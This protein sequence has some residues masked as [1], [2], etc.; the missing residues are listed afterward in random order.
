MKFYGN[1]PIKD[2]KEIDMIFDLYESH[3][4]VHKQDVLKLKAYLTPPTVEETCK[5]LSNYYNEEVEYSKKD[6]TFESKDTW[7]ACYKDGLVDFGCDR[8]P[9]DIALIIIRFYKGEQKWVTTLQKQVVQC[10]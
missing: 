3:G 4:I 7:Y 8:I 6:R 5:A 9:L 2:Q 10:L 1:E